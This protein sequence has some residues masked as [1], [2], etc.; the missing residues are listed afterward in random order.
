MKPELK[1]KMTPEMIVAYQKTN[2][3]K[4][5]Q[6]YGSQINY[7][8]LGEVKNEMHLITLTLPEI[9]ILPDGFTRD[10]VKLA[11]RWKNANVCAAECVFSPFGDADKDELNEVIAAV[12]FGETKKK[13][14]KIAELEETINELVEASPELSKKRGR[15]S[16]KNIEI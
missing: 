6:A 14:D 3:Y 9:E 10:F 1:K 4:I 7:D 13:K 8:H 2:V 11:E 16:Q 12:F 15:K 5:L